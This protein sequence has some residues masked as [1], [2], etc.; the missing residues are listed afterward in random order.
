[1][2]EKEYKIKKHYKKAREITCQT[3]RGEDII[4]CQLFDYNDIKKEGYGTYNNIKDLDKI[5]TGKPD[6]A[7]VSGFGNISADYELGGC[8]LIDFKPKGLPIEQ[9]LICS[10]EF[11]EKIDK[12]KLDKLVDEVTYN[13]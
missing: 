13:P 6:I 12:S 9:I 1:M 3:Q 2:S 7:E 10:P 5:V 4:G 8:V 11:E